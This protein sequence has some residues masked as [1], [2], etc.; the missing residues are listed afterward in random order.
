MERSLSF[1][2]L[3]FYRT[4][5]LLFLLLL[6]PVLV[7]AD[8]SVYEHQIQQARN[9]NYALFLDYLQRYEQQHALTPGQVA[10]W[11]QVASWAGRDDEVIRVW[12]RYGIYMPLPARAIAAV[13]QSRRNQKAWP[14]ALSLWKEALSLAP[15]NDDYRIGYVKTLADARKDRL[16]L[17][18]AR[19]LVKD[20][21]S[22]AHLETLSYVWMRQGKNRDRLLADMRALSAAPGNEALLRETI[23][24]LTDNRVSTPA[25]WLSQNAALSPAERRRLE[26]NAAA[27]RV[28]LADVP[29]R[30]EKERLRLAQ[31]ALDRYHAL[32]SRW[33]NDP[34]AAE[35]VILARIDRLGAL[36]AQGNYRQVISEYESLTAAQHPVPDW[37]IGWV[38]S[39]YLQEKNTVAAFSLVQRYP[40]YASDPQDEEHALFYAWLDTGQYQAARRYVERETRSVPWTRYDFGSPTAQPNDRWLTGQ[41]LKFNYLLATNALPE[42]EKLSYRLASTAPGNQGLQIDYAALLQARGLPRAAEQKL[43]RAEALEP[44]NLELEK[45]QAYVAMD[46]QEWRQ[47]DLLANN[48]IARAPADRSARRLDRL[49][50]VH[51]MSEL[52]LNAAKGLHSDNPVSGS[53]DMNWD[54]TLYGPPVADNWRLFAGTRYAQ[55]NFDEGKGISRHLLG[56]VEWRPRDLT[57]EA[58]LSG[59]RYHGKN[60]PGARLSTTYSLSDN[61]QVSGNLERLSRATPLRALR[62]GISANRGEGGVRWY[63]NERREY[64][65]N[66]AISRFSDHNRRQEYT[67]SGKER[68]WQ[69]PTLTLELEPGI[70]AS[71][72]SLRNTLYYNPARDLSVTAALSVDHEMYRHYDTLWSQQFV[73]G[74]GS[75]WQK[76]QSPGAVTL[77]GYGQRIQWNNVVDT[78]VMLNWDKRPYDGKRESNL[79][80][81]LDATLRF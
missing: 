75:Y 65:F 6:F 55:G 74:G 35:D 23:D 44:T 66:A 80:V 37:A 62:N 54:A 3:F 20:N 49:R 30:T 59:N 39:A 12:Q 26:R 34:Q 47:M 52:R 73:A 29:G 48:V 45:Q 17:S 77:L 72:N 28:R 15:D 68:L 4:T 9:G 67:L 76:N 61:W 11:L 13:A 27:E 5:I 64:Q 18:E 22:P 81:T 14:S 40:H 19:Q 7:Q 46:L 41:S 31:N 60:R 38:I 50:M 71:K 1:T 78:G 63:Q 36:Y 32:L 69:T 25:L 42:A 58:E 21:P 16:A 8:E 10:D 57:L 53:H 24:A 33:Q 70:A 51:H 2:T 56:G 79:S 43:K